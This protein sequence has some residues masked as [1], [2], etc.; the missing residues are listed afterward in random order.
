MYKQAKKLFFM[1]SMALAPCVLS[2]VTLPQLSAQVY[3]HVH[4]QLHRASSHYLYAASANADVIELNDGS[5]WNVAPISRHLLQQHPQWG[6]TQDL[7]IKPK[8]TGGC[9]AILS[10]F[11]GYDYVIRNK[12]LQQTIFVNLRSAPMLISEHT[13][14]ISYIDRNA[15]TVFLNDNSEWYIDQSDKNFSYWKEGDRIILGLNNKWRTF[16]QVSYIMINADMDGFPYSIANIRSYSP[17]R[18]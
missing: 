10:Y 14:F 17:Y 12:A 5:R 4:S 1:F 2:Y 18:Q 11:S 9:C 15:R 13:L 8:Y 16:S 3:D 6:Y 7:E